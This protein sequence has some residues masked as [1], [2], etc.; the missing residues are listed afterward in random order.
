MKIVNILK[1]I[2][3][4]VGRP[5]IKGESREYPQDF[6]KHEIGILEKATGFTMT[7]LDAQISLIRIVDYLEN[8]KIEGCFV[9]C[10]V[11]RGGSSM[12][13]AL[14]LLVREAA[15]R[16]LYLYDTFEGMTEPTLVDKTTD[17]KTARQHMDEDHEKKMVWC[18]AGL[19]DVK[20]N[21]A[22]T[23]YP[24]NR[25]KYI[26]GP[27]E[28]TLPNQAPTEPIALLRL[29]TDWYESTRHELENLYPRLVSG[30]ILVIDDY[31]YWEGSKRATD[32]FFKNK[33]IRAYFH[34]VDQSQRIFVKP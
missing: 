12:I 30:G 21:L 15:M 9:E 10:G 6:L 1:R 8:E 20:K 19:E 23:Q 26:Q 32:E 4:Y 29:D 24:T 16:S 7:T 3:T 31:G 28:A 34:R 11:W 5:N 33:K 2:K 25:I 17:G 14:S 27:V 13:M 22:S 18:I